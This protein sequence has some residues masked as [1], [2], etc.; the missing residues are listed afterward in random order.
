MLEKIVYLHAQP[1]QFAHYLRLGTLHRQVET[2]LGSGRMPLDRIVVEASAFAHQRDVV[3][4][5]GEL[6]RELILDT[7][8]AELSAIGRCSGAAKAA[9]W[10]YL[11]GPLQREHFTRGSSH[12]VIGM[13]ARFVVEKGF[14][15]VQAPTHLLDG[16]TDE[17]FS[18][19]R[20]T[21]VALRRALD[22]EGGIHIPI[23]YPVTIKNA[24]LRDAAERRA[25]IA[26]LADLPFDNL[27]LRISGFGADAPATLLRG[28]IAAVMDFQRL[29]KPIVADGVGG[30]AALATAAFGAAGGVCHG[31]GEKERFDA[32]DWNKPPA[33]GG[34]GR[35]KRVLIPGLDRLLTVK[36]IGPLMEAHGARKLLSCTDPNCCPR[37]LDDMLN[38]PKAHYLRQR[39]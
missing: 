23:D 27:W 24:S 32:S 5:M 12:D 35:E 33:A 30:L 17:W 1:E 37:G 8:V 28:Y 16:A 14:H 2:L 29:G 3:A 10:A 11:D 7:N 34:G 9:P 31:L 20:K 6:G 39:A 38:N 22:A 18:T 21:C 36:Q 25:L 26:G 13:I 15:A 4:L 19:D